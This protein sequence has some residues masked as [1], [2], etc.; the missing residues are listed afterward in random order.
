MHSFFLGWTKIPSDSK[1]IGGEI[2][3]SR[4]RV[5]TLCYTLEVQQPAVSF[6]WV[7]FFVVGPP[8]NLWIFCG[9]KQVYVINTSRD[10]CLKSLAS[11]VEVQKQKQVEGTYCTKQRCTP[12]DYRLGIPLLMFEDLLYINCSCY[13]HWERTH[14]GPK[15]QPSWWMTP[16]Q[17]EIPQT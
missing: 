2:S 10:F 8:K 11:K 3:E 13:F 9:W 7:F 5:A 6:R 15:N 14:N 12:N 1:G 17:V 4:S 16:M